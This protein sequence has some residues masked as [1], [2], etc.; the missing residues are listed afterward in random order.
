MI[1]NCTAGSSF[2]QANPLRKMNK[3]R[4]SPSEL[5]LTANPNW[6]WLSHGDYLMI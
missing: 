2:S 6:D 1:K 3:S 4:T 5:Q